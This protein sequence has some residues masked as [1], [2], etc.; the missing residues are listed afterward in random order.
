MELNSRQAQLETYMSQVIHLMSSQTQF[1]QILISF[2]G[3]SP[4]SS[5]DKSTQNEFFNVVTYQITNSTEVD[6]KEHSI[7]LDE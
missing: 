3:Y 4:Y 7:R 5:L 2:L 6:Y 1:N